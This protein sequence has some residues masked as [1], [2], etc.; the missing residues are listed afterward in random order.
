MVRVH[1]WPWHNSASSPCKIRSILD[2]NR[3][4]TLRHDHVNN[5]EVVLTRLKIIVTHTL[6]KSACHIYARMIVKQIFVKLVFRRMPVFLHLKSGGKNKRAG[7]QSTAERIKE[8]GKHSRR[9]IG[10]LISNCSCNKRPAWH[11]PSHH[12]LNGRSRSWATVS[13]AVL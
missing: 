9:A 2:Q 10:A 7:A 11:T 6:C 13:A 1:R 3:I 5:L 8:G 12:Q 4:Q